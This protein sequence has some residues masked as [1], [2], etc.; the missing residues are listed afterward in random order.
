MSS[1][2][3][4]ALSSHLRCLCIINRSQNVYLSPNF[5]VTDNTKSIHSWKHS[6]ETFSNNCPNLC[7]AVI[8]IKTRSWTHKVIRCYLTSVAW[9]HSLLGHK[10]VWFIE[11]C[12]WSASRNL[13][14]WRYR[15][16]VSFGDNGLRHLMP[17]HSHPFIHHSCVCVPFSVG[18]IKE[19]LVAG[20]I[21][22]SVS[23]WRSHLTADG[24]R[25]RTGLYQFNARCSGV[26]VPVVR[27]RPRRHRAG[28]GS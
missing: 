16:I 2:L 28:G 9:P 1:C 27:Q 25:G 3:G 8:M 18:I 17:P 14:K 7:R 26:Q 19:Q 15:G 21:P 22:W 20:R 4:A 13:T 6:G 24:C 5:C 12:S 11:F 23:A 10:L